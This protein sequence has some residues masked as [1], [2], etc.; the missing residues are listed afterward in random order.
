VNQ[1]HQSRSD[2][3]GETVVDG[4]LSG[5]EEEVPSAFCLLQDVL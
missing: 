2:E 3:T 1:F 5:V 4:V